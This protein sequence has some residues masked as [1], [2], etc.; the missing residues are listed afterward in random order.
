MAAAQGTKE[1]FKAKKQELDSMA[2][3]AKFQ[4]AA[5]STDKHSGVIKSAGNKGTSREGK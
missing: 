2:G 3:S 4:D 1:D 5:N